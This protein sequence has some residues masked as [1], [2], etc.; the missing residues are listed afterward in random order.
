[1]KSAIQFSSI[2]F[3]YSI[4]LSLHPTKI[5]NNEAGLFCKADQLQEEPGLASRKP[6][7]LLYPLD[8]ADDTIKYRSWEVPKWKC[9][10]NSGLVLGTY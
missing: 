3:V 7:Q 9:L 6:K 1:M 8:H 4:D 5:E 10:K 2:L